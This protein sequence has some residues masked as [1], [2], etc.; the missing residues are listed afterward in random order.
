VLAA[1]IPETDYDL[2]GLSN[3]G[4]KSPYRNVRS[5][6]FLPDESPPFLPGDP[7]LPSASS[8]SPGPL[9]MT[10]GSGAPSATPS[11]ASTAG[12]SSITARGAAST[13]T[14]VSGSSTTVTPSGS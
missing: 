4:V 5:Y 1:R 8:S 2:Q 10:S 11:T 7:F 14:D 12:V 3:S 9:P 6:Y 13:A